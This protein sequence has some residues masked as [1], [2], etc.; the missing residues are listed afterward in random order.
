MIDS[1][2]TFIG[3]DGALTL[4]SYAG[5]VYACFLVAEW[6]DSDDEQEVG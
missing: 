3:F 2:L 5:I 1:I 4:T 6:I